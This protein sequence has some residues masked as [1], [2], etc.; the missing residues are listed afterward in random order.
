MPRLPGMV[1]DGL[2]NSVSK[3]GEEIVNQQDKSFLT[4]FTA[5]MGV[6][7][8]L[9]VAIFL[10]ARLVSVVATYEPDD[11]SRMASAV[12]GRLTPVGRVVIASAADQEAASAGTADMTGETV[13]AQ[14]CSGCHQAGVLQAPK[15]GSK[16]DWEPRFALGL[17]TLV[18]HAVNGLNAMPPKGGNPALTDEQ[19]RDAVLDML[20]Q[21]GIEAGTQSGTEQATPTEAASPPAE[22]EESS[23][24]TTVD[25]AR[26]KEVYGQ[27]CFACH[28]TGAANAPKFADNAAWQ[29]RI[30]QGM[31]TLVSHAINGL[32]AMPPKGGAM[33]LSD[34][35]IA[36]AVA[37]M[38]DAAK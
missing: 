19:I 9:A 10:G 24:G 32:N 30:E 29:P 33:H 20:A 34:E 14:V 13:V 15:I 18:S 22:A 25:L 1:C 23:E 7:V 38:V 27:A 11:G 8:L 21:T 28:D 5:I 37:Y 3:Q 35:D 31:E 17:D 6:L 36:A 16:E 26:G 4:V 2:G 12:E